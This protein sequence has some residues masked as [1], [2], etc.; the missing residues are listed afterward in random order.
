MNV[1]YK[2]L[3][4]RAYSLHSQNKLQEAEELYTLLLKISPDDANILN[5][6]GMLCITKGDYDKAIM[7]ISK[8]VILNKSVYV[9]TNLAKA[10]MANSQYDKAVKILE[11]IAKTNPSDDLFYSLAIAYK[12]MSNTISAISA[13][14]SAININPQN[15]NACYNLALIY[16]DNKEIDNA[17]IYALKAYELNK[18]DEDISSLLS[19]IYEL[20]NDIVNAIFYLKNSA[21][22]NPNQYLY[23]YNLAVLY[24]KINEKNNAIDYYKKV[25]ELNPNHIQTLVN[26]SVIYRQSSLETSLEYILKAYSINPEEKNVCLNLAQV[27][28]DKFMNI[29]SLNILFKMLSSNKK[30][31]EAYALIAINYMDM[32]DYKNALINYELAIKYEPNNINY[33]HGKASALKYLGYFNEAKLIMKKIVDENPDAIQSATTLGMMYLSE[34]NFKEG[35]KLYSLR[36]LDT[37]FSELFKNNIW[38]IDLKL[39]N[40]TVVVY[41]DCG[42]GD[43]IMFARYLPFLNKIAKKVI[44]Q[45]DKELVSILKNSFLDILVISK[46]EKL[47]EYDIAIPIMNLPYA[48]NMDFKNPV[49]SN[50]YLNSNIHNCNLLQNTKNKKIGLFWQGNKRV[51][52]NRSIPFSEIKKLLIEP[53]N[54]YSF[55]IENN[56]E[57]PNLIK[58]SEYISDYSDT[59][60]FLK[61]IDLLITIDSSIVHVA[62]SLGVKTFLL[63]PYTPE[64]RWYNDDNTTRWYDSVTIFK[65]TKSGDWNSVIER[66]KNAIK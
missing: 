50:S 39:D 25:L 13:Y 23:N 46:T 6:Y 64:W 2:E 57:H 41:S 40:K 60:S 30:I 58:L 27:Y 51:F 54:F 34:D 12:K 11:E 45:T 28:K 33:Q 43:T 10:Y 20:K 19:T 44:L 14:I 9:C 49:L 3:T 35:M 24:S 16:I 65:Q 47:P 21:K 52:K 37:K 8:A 17:L 42:L 48:L 1:R 15:Y 18:N 26:L 22:I 29:E 36:S 53:Y 7:L 63:L 55:Q 59:A 31:P 56:E 38:N 4:D 5:L 66:V 62:G 32:G 61:Q